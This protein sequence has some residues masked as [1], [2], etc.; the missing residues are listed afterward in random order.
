MTRIPSATYRLQLN[1][2]FT[3]ADAE[4]VL[5]YLVALGISHV[6]LSPIRTSRKGSTHGYDVTDPTQVDPELGGEAALEEFQAALRRLGLGL[7]ADVVPNHMAA[8]SE[9]RW[10]MDVLEQGPGSAYAS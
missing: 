10:W 4:K 7:I 2:Q 8:S 9:N 3:F 6:Y 5:D 1:S